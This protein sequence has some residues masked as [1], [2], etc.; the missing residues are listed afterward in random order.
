M[1][2]RI[3]VI[4]DN[5]KLIDSLLRYTPLLFPNAEFHVVSIVDYSYEIMSATS[6]VDESLERSAMRALL[7]CIDNLKEMGIHAKRGFYKGNFEAIVENYVGRERIDLVATE[8]PLEMDQKRSHIS[9]HLEKIF[10]TPIRNVMI[11][12]RMPSLRRPERVFIVVGDSPKSWLAAERG[13][14]LCKEFEASCG[15]S[16]AGKKARRAVYESFSKLARQNEI[17]FEVREFEW[18][19]KEEIPSFL[20]EFDFLVM[21]RGGYRL[22]D[23]LKMIVKAL[24]LSRGE[25]NVLLY[26]PIPVLLVGGNGG[27]RW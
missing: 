6:F 27:R 18:R 19:M 8:T 12:N 15:M 16:Y 13:I 24:P 7:H 25:I 17:D 10:R 26:A 2:K 1:F 14:Q 23:Q 11:L 20:E 5:Y 22:R 9:W 3:M 21:S 4:A